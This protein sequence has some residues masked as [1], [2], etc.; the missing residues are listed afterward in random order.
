MTDWYYSSKKNS[1]DCFGSTG[2]LDDVKELAFALFDR[3]AAPRS[4]RRAQLQYRGLTLDGSG[5]S[6]AEGYV[7]ACH[8]T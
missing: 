2:P 7:A 6:Y 5:A 1:N 8:D 4:Q 3:T